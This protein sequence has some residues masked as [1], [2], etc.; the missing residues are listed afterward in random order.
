MAAPTS[1]T[2]SEFYLQYV[3][4]YQIIHLLD[5]SQILGTSDMFMCFLLFLV[6]LQPL[7]QT[8]MPH[9]TTFTTI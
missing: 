9:P 2:S 6:N 5:R 7:L 1:A 4:H 3:Q 8:C